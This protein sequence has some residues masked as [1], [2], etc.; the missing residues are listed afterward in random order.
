MPIGTSMRPVLAILPAS[1]KTLVPL[2]PAV[3]MR[4][5]PVAAVVR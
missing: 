5:E 1:A 2:L 4:G 3:P